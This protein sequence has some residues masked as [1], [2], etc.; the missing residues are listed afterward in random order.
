[1]IEECKISDGTKVRIM[2]IGATQEVAAAL[3]SARSAGFRAGVDA[4]AVKA[5]AHATVILAAADKFASVPLRLAGEHLHE[6]AAF[7]RAIPE[8]P[9]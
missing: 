2:N 9:K 5:S 7:I 3:A 8:P 4:A 6:L 1:M